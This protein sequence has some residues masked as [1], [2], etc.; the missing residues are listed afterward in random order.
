MVLV[1]VHTT[2]L[3]AVLVNP[4]EISYLTETAPDIH[5]NMSNGRMLTIGGT[6]AAQFIDYLRGAER[7]TI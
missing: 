7:L 4:E 2:N 3:G 6:T 1:I 5:L